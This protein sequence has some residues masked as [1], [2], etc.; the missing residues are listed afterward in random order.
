MEQTL[1]NG[2]KT[3]FLASHGNYISGNNI[4]GKYI[5]GK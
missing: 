3:K 4:F 1:G 2:E 5:S